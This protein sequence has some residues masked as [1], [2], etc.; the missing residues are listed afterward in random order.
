MTIFRKYIKI[1]W[2]IRKFKFGFGVLLT[3]FCWVITKTVRDTGHIN[4]P[5]WRSCC[6]KKMH[7]NPTIYQKVKMR[8]FPLL[9][10]FFV[11][12]GNSYIITLCIFVKEKFHKFTNKNPIYIRWNINSV[13]ANNRNIH[14]RALGPQMGGV[15][16]L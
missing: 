10:H 14:V 8:H 15:T 13:Y 11:K 7:R 16:I 1:G 5:F 9:G 6:N 12:N 4:N 2:K 3:P